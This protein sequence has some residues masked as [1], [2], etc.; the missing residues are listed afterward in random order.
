MRFIPI[1]R[2]P[3]AMANTKIASQKMMDRRQFILQKREQ[4]RARVREIR[5]KAE[6]R[7]KP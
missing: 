4:L 3:A 5:L 1:K 6:N 2:D 7:D